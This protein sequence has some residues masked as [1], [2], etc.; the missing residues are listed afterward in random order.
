M[1]LDNLVSVQ[2]ALAE[3]VPQLELATMQHARDIT[4]ER[5]TNPQI[6]NQ[7]FWT[8]DGAVYRVVIDNEPVLDLTQGIDNPVLADVA[9]ASRQLLSTNNYVVPAPALARVID[10]FGGDRTLEVKLSALGLTR[11]DDEF[12][13]F[14]IGTGK[15]EYAKL[16]P[17][18]RQVAEHVYG[19]KDD[20]A[21]AMALLKD[22]GHTN[23]TR[24]WVLNPDYVR[25]H[26]PKDG[27]LAR[28]SGLGR[29]GDGSWF[30]ADDRGVGDSYG[31]VRGVRRV[32]AAE[33]G[34]AAQATPSVVAVPGGEYARMYDTILAKPGDALRDL[35][36][37]R[38]DGL[39]KLLEQYHAQAKK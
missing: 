2:G 34:A 13:Y 12:S 31:R 11:H 3:T 36:A 6:R 15:R 5:I 22:V 30:D 26:V 25:E 29:L 16:S 20:F 17:A 4:K 32:V 23:S 33:G 7:W 21:P 37:V 35:N 9:E 28:A 24:V 8:A 39:G 14:D 1:V 19:Q 27:A 38:A 10:S 18:Q